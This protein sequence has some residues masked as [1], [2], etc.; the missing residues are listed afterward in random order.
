MDVRV[1]QDLERVVQAS[2][3]IDLG[4]VDAFRTAIETASR[5]SP[6]GFVIDLSGVQYMDSAGVQA[7]L[8][9]YRLVTDAGGRLALVIAHPNVRVIFEVI[10]ADR[11]PGLLIFDRLAPAVDAIHNA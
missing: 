9:A 1:V 2:G 8:S 3:E 11:L 10:G 6:R 5:E 4:N 7:V